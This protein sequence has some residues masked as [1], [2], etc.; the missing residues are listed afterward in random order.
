M[1]IVKRIGLL[2]YFVELTSAI[3]VV[4]ISECSR[5]ELV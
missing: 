2:Q 4:D 3:N 5:K 1:M